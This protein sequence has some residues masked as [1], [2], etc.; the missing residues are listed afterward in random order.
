MRPLWPVAGLA[1]LNGNLAKQRLLYCDLFVT[2]LNR[3]AF[4]KLS[5]V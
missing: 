2:D 3:S 4:L 5:A 1:A